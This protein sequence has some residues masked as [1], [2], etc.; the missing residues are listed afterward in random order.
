[1]S[2]NPFTSTNVPLCSSLLVVIPLGYISP[3]WGQKTTSGLSAVVRSTF[4]SAS[5]PSDD[6]ETEVGEEA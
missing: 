3:T 1:M 4:T 5:C 6:G 2:P